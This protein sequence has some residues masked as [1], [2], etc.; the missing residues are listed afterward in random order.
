MKS[1]V[2]IERQL[3][4][5]DPSMEN[6]QIVDVV[7]KYL[8]DHPENRHSDAAI[9]VAVALMKTFPCSAKGDLR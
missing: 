2:V 7:V 1:E 6:G 9:L 3:F 8:K 4:C 5:P